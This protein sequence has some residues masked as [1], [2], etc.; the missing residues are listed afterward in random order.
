[1][2]QGTS[3]ILMAV[4]ALLLVAPVTL[5]FLIGVSDWFFSIL[6]FSVGWQARLFVLLIASS[7]LVA[8]WWLMVQFWRHGSGR[9]VTVPKYVWALLTLAALAVVVTSLLVFA[10]SIFASLKPRF[11]DFAILIFGLPLLIPLAHLVIERLVRS[12]VRPPP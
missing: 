5:L 8:G 2:T 7:S 6:E 3:K 4:E 12:T 10:S 9:L 11:E 1:M